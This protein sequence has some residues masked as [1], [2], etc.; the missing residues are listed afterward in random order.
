MTRPVPRLLAVAA[1]VLLLSTGCGAG[2]ETVDRP[3]DPAA[4]VFPGTQWDR[5]TETPEVLADIDERTAPFFAR[6]PAQGGPKGAMVVKN[7]RVV[8]ERYASGFTASSVMQSFSVAKSILSLAVGIAIDDGVIS[9]GDSA[10]NPAW[11]PSDPRS[12]I[13]VENLLH[14]RSGLEWDEDFTDG[15]PSRMLDVPTGAADM[16]ARRDLVKPPGSVFSY[17]TGNSAILAAYLNRQL[18]GGDA[19]VNFVGQRLLR[20]LGVTSMSLLKD[21][22]G[23]WVGGIGADATLSDWARIGWMVLN[24][25]TWGDARIVS[26]EW[27]RYS[28]QP[29]DLEGVYLAHWW[30]LSPNAVAAVGLHGQAIIIDDLLHTVVTVAYGDAPDEDEG[31]QLG[32]QLLSSVALSYAD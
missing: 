26:E 30:K 6:T 24:G 9:L 13:T 23:Q 31:L 18:G 12:R 15:D 1:A 21:S 8:W 28:Q 17:S 10:L 27:L 14:M 29:K 3:D 2:T 7:G 20:P 19:L 22:S 5:G 4:P 16:A 11:G 32:L 25:G